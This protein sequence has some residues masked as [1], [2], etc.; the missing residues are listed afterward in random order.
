VIELAGQPAQVNVV[1]PAHIAE[2]E[3]PLGIEYEAWGEQDDVIALVPP[4]VG[5]ERHRVRGGESAA[6][7]R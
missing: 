3:P 4:G 6:G 7:R 5:S 1:V 2:R